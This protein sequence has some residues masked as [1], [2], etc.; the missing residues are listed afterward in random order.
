METTCSS[1][2]PELPFYPSAQYHVPGYMNLH[3]HCC[4]NVVSCVWKCY[5]LLWFNIFTFVIHKLRRY[6]WLWPQK[7]F[8]HWRNTDYLIGLIRMQLNLE[9]L[10][11]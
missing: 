1:K 5:S 7:F 9:K 10:A 3:E 8:W 11:V 2:M 4:E 6:S